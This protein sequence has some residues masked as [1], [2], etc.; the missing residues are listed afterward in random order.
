[1]YIILDMN[2]VNPDEVPMRKISGST[3]KLQYFDI[4]MD[5][6]D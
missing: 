1:M 4:E 3:L 2:T 6:D 5:L